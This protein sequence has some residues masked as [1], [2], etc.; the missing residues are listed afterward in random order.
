[1]KSK[2]AARWALL[3]SIMC[4]VCAANP[5]FAK[6]QRL[7][8]GSSA[9]WKQA[10]SLESI[11]ELPGIRPSPVL[12]LGSAARGNTAGGAGTVAADGLNLYL[13]F[14]EG[15][16]ELFTDKTGNWSVS[17]AGGV[18]AAQA[19]W[20]R[21]GMGAAFFSGSTPKNEVYSV[22]SGNGP[23]KIM[24][25]NNAIF[26]G[27][28]PVRDFSIEFWLYPRLMENGEQIF[29]WSATHTAASTSGG[30]SGTAPFFQ[31]IQCQTSKN[32]LEWLFD[33]FF[34]SAD[35]T[36][37]RS[38]T[39]N[40]NDPVLPVAWSHHLVRFDSGS[41]LLEYLVDG[42][43]ACVR[44]VTTTGHEIGE[45]FQPKAGERGSIIVG[46]GFIGLLDELKIY[47]DFVDAG[48]SARFPLTGG[49]MITDFL[50]LGAR[51][52]NVLRVEA[53]GGVTNCQSGKKAVVKKAAT[54]VLDFDSNAQIKLFA[55]FSD[56]PWSGFGDWQPVDAA[57]TLASGGGPSRGRFI[58][59]AADF[60]PSGDGELTP[61]L[62][63]LAV[64]YE[65]K[66]LPPPP[67][68]VTA[69]A[70]DG[71]IT[72]SWRPVNDADIGGYLVYYGKKSGNYLGGGA[73]NGLSPID[74]GK[75]ETLT[76]SGL[77][78]GSLYFFVVASYD[79]INGVAESGVFSKEIAARPV[80]R[81]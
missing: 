49:K 10:A 28:R 70:G 9:T 19:G 40:S 16:T 31:R 65:A 76:I 7:V 68:Y 46:S 48:D 4:A 55:R 29:V 58:Q 50:D 69:T 81:R 59:I 79:N 57:G 43:I 21:R 20:A 80:R 23:V 64:V 5:L 3:F 15:R 17:T 32:R 30:V 12:A 56:S 24:P 51:N 41:G 36:R 53:S 74:A 71:Q 1:M 34:V 60:Y 63:E 13:A 2:A 27:G 39:L 33:E 11:V 22:G 66:G 78:N 8:L 44:H 6:E 45:V 75:M 35:G 54:G 61:F 67:A 38:I 62:E 37:S 47:S 25:G 73:D 52:S 26:A 18:Q 72:L 42:K 14:D 77:D